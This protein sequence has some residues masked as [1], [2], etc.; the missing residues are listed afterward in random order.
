[1]AIMSE[2]AA[3]AFRNVR[4]VKAFANEDDEARK[5]KNGNMQV[6][7]MGCKKAFY[8][9]IYSSL[10]QVFLYGAMAGVIYTSKEI[11]RRNTT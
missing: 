7:D 5:F 4:T 6:Y 11:V 10:V 9:G 2:V 3:E 8:Q 1:M